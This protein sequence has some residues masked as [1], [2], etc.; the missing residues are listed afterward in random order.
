MLRSYR[1]RFLIK[2]YLLFLLILNN[3]NF[4]VVIVKSIIVLHNKIMG[5]SY[6][7]ASK[8]ISIYVT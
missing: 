5:K 6:S 3:I 1:L 7:L 4:S 8:Y 2:K